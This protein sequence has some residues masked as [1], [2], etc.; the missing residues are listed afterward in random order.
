MLASM[1]AV[2]EG[3]RGLLTAVSSIVWLLGFRWEADVV[4]EEYC[5]K[6]KKL[7]KGLLDELLLWSFRVLCT[8]RDCSSCS[9]SLT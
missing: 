9:S 4:A 5:G 2:T 6:V 3:E 7:A 1:S 8:S